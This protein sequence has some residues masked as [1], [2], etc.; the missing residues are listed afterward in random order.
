MI[1]VRGAAAWGLAVAIAVVVAFSAGAGRAQ[2]EPPAKAGGGPV[3]RAEALEVGKRLA[4]AIVRLDAKAFE[5]AMDME[6]LMETATAGVKA[7]D[8]FKQDFLKGAREAQG[9][10]GSPLLVEFRPAVKAGARVRVTRGLEWQGKPAFLLRM[11]AADGN[12]SYLVFLVERRPGGAIKAV[13][14]YSLATGEL[15]SQAAHRLYV[16]TLAQVNRGLLDR[17]LGQD[18]AFLKHID[19][20]K[21]MAASNREGRGTDVLT[22]YEALPE[23]LKNEKVFQVLRFSGAQKTGDNAKY[24]EAIRDFARRFPGDPACEF[25]LVDGYFLMKQPEKSLGCIDNLEKTLG[26]D[27]YLK[28]LRANLLTLLKRPD[29]ALAEYRAAIAAE[30]DLRPAYDGLLAAALGRKK[31]AEVAKVLDG[32]ESQLHQEINDLSGVDEFKEFLASPEGQAWARA[33]KAKKAGDGKPK[34]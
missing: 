5:G 8:R 34:P 30:P 1:R 16:S 9:R 25:L 17:V 2:E 33:Q 29:D 12:A 31:F 10:D 11:I 13:D 6:A 18:Q 28:V 32:L 27:A 3:S 14:Y 23:E 19:D 24:L 4:D 15:A 21:R 7:P 20:L 22:I 26:E